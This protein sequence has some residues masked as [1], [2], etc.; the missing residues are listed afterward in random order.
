M[1]SFFVGVSFLTFLDL[2]ALCDLW[3]RIDRGLWRDV[4]TIFSAFV[5]FTDAFV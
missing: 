1:H 5:K 4:L 2:N 3:R